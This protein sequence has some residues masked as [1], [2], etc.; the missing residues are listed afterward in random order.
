[1]C[2]IVVLLVVIACWIVGDMEVRTKLIFTGLYVASWAL[3][4]VDPWIC[5]GVQSVLGLVIGAFTFAGGRGR[6]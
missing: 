2:G 5:I 1:M 6:R 4:A 3:L